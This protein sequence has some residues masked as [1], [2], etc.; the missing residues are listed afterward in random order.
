MEY[1]MSVL[2]KIYKE[3]SELKELSLRS[4]LE[5]IDI[6]EAS[7][8][9]RLKKSYMYGLIH[10]NQIPFYKPNGKKVYFKKCELNDWIEKSKV[11]ALDEVEKSIQKQN[12]TEV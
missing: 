4:Q 8:H 3:I 10:R 6:D 5:F 2:D 12:K 1:V 11:R 7:K 9:L